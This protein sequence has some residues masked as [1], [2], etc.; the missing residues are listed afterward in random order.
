[1]AALALSPQHDA[2]MVG[3]AGQH[4][5]QSISHWGHG[6]AQHAAFAVLTGTVLDAQHEASFAAAAFVEQQEAFS[7]Q[8]D[9]PGSQHSVFGAALSWQQGLISAAVLS[10]QFVPA[11]SLKR[12]VWA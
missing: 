4:T 11:H 1:M 12:S 2:H 9:A 6:S 3:Q 7:S 5:E 10:G 8:H